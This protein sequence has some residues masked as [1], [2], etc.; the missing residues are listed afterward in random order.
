VAR[1]SPPVLSNDEIEF[2]IINQVDNVALTRGIC[3]VSKG[4]R[5]GKFS[6]MILPKRN[7]SIKVKASL[8]STGKI[9]CRLMYEL[10]DQ[11]NESMPIIEGYQVFIA[12]KTFARPR[13]NK[14]KVSAVMFVAKYGRFPGKKDKM[15][16]LLDG[17]LQK[18][19]V[20]NAS[21]FECAIKDQT[22][23]LKA[24]FHPDRAII[25]ITLKEI[26]GYTDK[27]PILFE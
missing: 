5:D 15:K 17:T 1:L 14:Y 16:R 4:E 24:V 25:E 19:L 22:L 18:R 21:S 23:R 11:R 20:N 2:M 8:S 27:R 26:G 7:A 3:H 10:V 6:A 9:E 12:V 13:A